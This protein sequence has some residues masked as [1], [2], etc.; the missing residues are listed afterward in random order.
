[1]GVGYDRLD[2]VALAERNVTV[3]NVPGPSATQTSLC[4]QLKTSTGLKD[5]RLWHR[6]NRRSRNRPR[7][8]PPPRDPLPPR[9][10]ARATRETMGSHRHAACGPS[11][12][13]N[14]RYPRTRTYRYSGCAPRQ[15]IR[16]ESYILRPL[17]CEWIRQGYWHRESTGYQGAFS[18]EQLFEYPLFV[19]AGNARH[20]G[21]GLGRVDASGLGIGEYRP[22]RGI[23]S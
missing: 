5:T 19:H 3:C 23:E 16:L 20:G 22:W 9:T 18:A 8:I 17:C 11:T 21:L 6:R 13:R 2:R 14:I 10:P 1:M 4:K 15:G 7:S 12:R